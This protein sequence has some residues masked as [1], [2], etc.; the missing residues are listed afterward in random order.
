MKSQLVLVCFSYLEPGSTGRAKLEMN[1][2]EAKQ[3]STFTAC[4]Q[5]SRFPPYPHGHPRLA[6]LIYH[7]APPPVPP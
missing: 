4:S 1:S 5:G 7:L 3:S 6:P 2:A